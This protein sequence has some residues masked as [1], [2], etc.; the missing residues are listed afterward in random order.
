MQYVHSY[1]IHK[2][3]TNRS[4]FCNRLLTFSEYTNHC[5]MSM[6][7]TFFHNTQPAGTARWLLL[8]SGIAKETSHPR[9]KSHPGLKKGRAMGLKI[10]IKKRQPNCLFLILS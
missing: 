9:L 2:L 6:L 5:K 7:I 10:Q 1:F 3:I 4:Y 8:F